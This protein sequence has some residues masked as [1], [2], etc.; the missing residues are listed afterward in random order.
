MKTWT[1][2]TLTFFVMLSIPLS[3]SAQS[4]AAADGLYKIQG[5]NSSLGAYSGQVWVHG[6]QVQRLIRWKT[7]RHEGKEVESIWS[8]SIQSQTFTFSLKLSNVLTG[9]GSYSPSVE[10]LRTPVQVSLPVSQISKGYSFN[11]SGEG[12]YT[13]T[14]KRVGEASA[15]PLW[16]DLCKNVEGV[17]GDDSGLLKIA[18][19]AGIDAVIA[20]YR[21][22]PE[23]QAY[24]DRSE[25]KEGKQ[26]FVQDKTD[27]HFYAKNPNVLRVTNKTINPLS[28][29]EALM[30]RNAYAPTLAQKAAF[31]G[32]QTQ[33]ENLNA[34]GILELALV[35]D[36]NMKVGRATEYDSALWTSMY[37]MSEVLRYE[38][39]KDPQALLNFRR[40]LDGI[41]TLTEITGSTTEFARSLAV[42]APTENIGEGWI[43]GTG[44]YS[45]LKWCQGG[46]NDM[47]KGLFITLALA[48]KIVSPKET[49][50]VAR[51]QRAALAM[52]R[53]QA[54]R[55][56]GYNN[57]VAHGLLALWSKDVTE[58]P[59]FY[60]S[61]VNLINQLGDKTKLEVGFYIGGVA[62]WSGINLTMASDLAQIFV[63]EELL[64]VFPENN[65][66]HYLLSVAVK[67]GQSRLFEM[68]KVYKNAHRDFLALIAYKYSP[69]ARKD[70]EFKAEARAALW[71]L[72]EVPAPRNVGD[73][74]VELAK[75]SDW[76]VSSWPRTPWKGMGF[77][78]V[79]EGRTF[80]DHGQGA[81]SYPNFET[82]AWQTT[83]YWKD[84]PFYLGYGGN[85]KVHSFSSDY[86][87][88]YW[89]ARA[90][91][92]ISEKE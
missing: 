52:T 75:L 46:N 9:F 40:V 31:L 90:S 1:R 62:D 26:Y 7:L 18:R 76:S 66:D 27:A 61:M 29:A 73:G 41:L 17:G 10:D 14:W 35:D 12:T 21:G 47:A 63:A 50:L 28:L 11:V 25:F 5:T 77:R 49:A 36:N 92:L 33:V 44:E 16:I 54:I 15:T 13:E 6:T 64:K 3:L 22:L 84:S 70:S 87:V 68:H 19:W 32:K 39:T 78:K 43:Q 71:T 81:Y 72:K 34:A 79:Q 23:T 30:R 20:W 53:F 58:L 60:N 67:Q 91:G 88:M 69:Q 45:H 4:R 83:F 56:R 51:I 48:H 8:G 86:L 2:L 89:A 82:L 55:E 24:K 38:A 65:K 37:G 85:S 57:G 74:R 80:A 42:S 59:L